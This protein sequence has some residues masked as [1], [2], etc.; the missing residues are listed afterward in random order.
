[1]EEEEEEG[2]RGYRKEEATGEMERGEKF[3]GCE[4]FKRVEGDRRRRKPRD[5]ERGGGGGKEGLGLK[6]GGKG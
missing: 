2:G 6:R 1:M 3:E 5:G 4:E